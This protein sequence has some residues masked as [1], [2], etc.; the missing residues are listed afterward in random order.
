VNDDEL[1]DLIE[2]GKTVNEVRFIEYMDVGGASRWSPSRVTSA[3][4]LE[5]PLLGSIRR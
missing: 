5:R 3:D 4:M 2:F 1:G